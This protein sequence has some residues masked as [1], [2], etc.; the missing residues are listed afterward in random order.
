MRNCCG[1]GYCK[2]AGLTALTFSGGII[3][4]AVLPIAAIAVIEMLFILIFGYMCLFK[5]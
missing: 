4:G 1:R 5:L 2:T 3:A